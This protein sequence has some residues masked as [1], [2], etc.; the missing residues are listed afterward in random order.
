MDEEAAGFE[1]RL[2]EVPQASIDL[3]PELLRLARILELKDA[4]KEVN[5][6]VLDHEG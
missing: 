2:P 1:C 3:I 4:V 5:P 6:R